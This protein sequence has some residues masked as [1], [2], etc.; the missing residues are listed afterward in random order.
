MNDI[1]RRKLVNLSRR[2]VHSAHFNSSN[3]RMKECKKELY[4]NFVKLKG[5]IKYHGRCDVIYG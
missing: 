1:K 3:A 2:I 5:T 4:L